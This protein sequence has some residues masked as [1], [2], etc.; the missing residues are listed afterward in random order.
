MNT[1][2]CKETWNKIRNFM[3]DRS[4][5]Q[6]LKSVR[7][8]SKLKWED[9]LTFLNILNILL[10][11]FEICHSFSYF[12]TYFWK[13]LFDDKKFNNLWKPSKTAICLE[14]GF[15]LLR[16][17]FSI[18][19]RVFI[20]YPFLTCICSFFRLLILVVAFMVD[21]CLIRSEHQKWVFCRELLRLHQDTG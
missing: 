12:A 8:L 2:K 18:N 11:F 13:H 14:S 21:G 16:I 1:R 10:M 19:R 7:I 4:Q 15:C 20:L 5:L 3:F 17:D 9:G 6:I